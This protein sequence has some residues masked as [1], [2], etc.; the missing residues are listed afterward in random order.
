GR[1][2]LVRR[3]TSLGGVETLAEHRAT[4]EPQSGIPDNLLRLSIGIEHIHDLELDLDRAL[5]TKIF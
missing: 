4:I 5:K 3:A 1:L 2:E